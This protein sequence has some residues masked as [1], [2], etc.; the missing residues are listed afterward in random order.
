LSKY[1]ACHGP[2]V[3]RK[4]T[5]ITNMHKQIKGERY[6][7]LTMAYTLAI[8]N[9]GKAFVGDDSGMVG[10][11]NFWRRFTIQKYG[12]KELLIETK[13]SP[14]FADFTRVF[15]VKHYSQKRPDFYDYINESGENQAKTWRH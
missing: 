12:D 4:E 1:T 9:E 5:T 13:T 3:T 10:G 15:E 2:K 11:Q 7:Y 14:H 8:Q 6:I